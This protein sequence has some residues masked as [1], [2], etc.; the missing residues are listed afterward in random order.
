MSQGFNFVEFVWI[1]I[2]FGVITWVI[3]SDRKSHTKWRRRSAFEWMQKSGVHCDS[4]ATLKKM[5]NLRASS[6]SRSVILSV[7]GRDVEVEESAVVGWDRATTLNLGGPQQLGIRFELGEEGV[8]FHC[9]ARP[10][11]ASNPYD[12]G[13]GRKVVQAMVRELRSQIEVEGTTGSG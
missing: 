12:F 8:R 4:V 10:R 2:I 6:V 11:F 13:R 7:G 3:L 5:S 1:V 9:C